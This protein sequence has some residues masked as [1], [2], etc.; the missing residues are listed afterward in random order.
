MHL[1]WY[2]SVGEN[3][4]FS[5]IASPRAYLTLDINFVTFVRLHLF[6]GTRNRYVSARVA[7]FESIRFRSIATTGHLLPWFVISCTVVSVLRQRHD[8]YNAN[9]VSNFWLESSLLRRLRCLVNPVIGIRLKTHSEMHFE[10]L[11]AYHLVLQ[12]PHFPSE[13]FRLVRFGSISTQLLKLKGT[14]LCVVFD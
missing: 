11:H 7:L 4:L 8:I 5:Y 14:R 3:R 13:T 6:Y 1:T 12:F 10:H 9:L 2:R